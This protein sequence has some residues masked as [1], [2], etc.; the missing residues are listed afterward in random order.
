MALHH[1]TLKA[2]VAKYAPLHAEGKTE[3]EV[4]QAIAADEKSY[5]ETAVAEIYAA[6]A[7]AGPEEEPAKAKK[8]VLKI[9]IRD[10]DDFS[11]VHAIGTDV[12]HFEAGRLQFL[13]DN[14][15]VE[16]K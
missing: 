14:G 12:S 7:G 10:K 2:A 8:H 4:K 11:K 9:E 3:A 15:Y 5:D 16:E 13:K 1:A 6:I